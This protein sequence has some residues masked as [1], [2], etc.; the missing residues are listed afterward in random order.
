MM[1]RFFALLALVALPASAEIPYAAGPAF[2]APAPLP[3]P[4]DVAR[5]VAAVA[6]AEAPRAG[7]LPGGRGW[8]VEAPPG[9]I[10]RPRLYQYVNSGVHQHQQYNSCGQAA[11]ATALT[12][13]GVKPED[14]TNA[15]MQAVYDAF[16][17]D[18]LWGRF[19]TSFQRVERALAAH[20]VQGAW[21]EGE[22]A[23]AET[24]KKGHLALAMLDV[25]ATEDEGW[26]PLG[27]HWVVVYAMDTQHVYLSN[28]PRDGRCTWR[29]FRKSWDTVMTR[30]FYGAPPWQAHRWFLVPHR[31]AAR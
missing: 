23:L 14:P 16:P 11:I 8:P 22:S 15:V 2:V 25:G 30:A 29:S 3:E 12:G 28:W 10:G 24:L 1:R 17:P 21:L 19:G 18:I 26:G 4:I 27:G 31:P 6:S 5:L 7:E 9:S 20:G 13:L